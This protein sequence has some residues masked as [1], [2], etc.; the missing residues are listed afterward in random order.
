[1][2]AQ[3]SIIETGVDKLVKLVRERGRISVSEATK[4][5]NVGS[6]VIMEWAEF[7]E[8]E[9]IISIE[10]TL[11]QPFLV[12]RKLTKEQV[13]EKAK[14][15]ESKRDV[16]V[17]KAETSLTFLNEQIEYLKKVKEEFDGLNKKF[18]EEMNVIRKDIE[19][20]EKYE[21]LRNKIND[22]LAQQKKDSR[23]KMGRKVQ[24]LESEQKKLQSILKGIKEEEEE[25]ER[26]KKDTKSI[27]ESEKK[28]HRKIDELKS[29]INSIEK[30]IEHEDSSVKISANRLDRL[31]DVIINVKNEIIKEKTSV[32]SLIKES[33]K[34]DETIKQMQKEIVKKIQKN[35]SKMSNA[36]VLSKSIKSAFGRKKELAELFESINKNS[37]ELREELIILVKK[38]KAFEL[39]S[40]SKDIGKDIAGLESK[41]DEVHKKRT[42]IGD[43]YK[44]LTHLIKSK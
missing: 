10:Y 17:S 20:I 34:H 37:E 19:E 41:F 42:A 29:L 4:L 27:D 15:F 16:F 21:Q 8:E 13:K 23:E 22:E 6:S 24:Q 33:K 9:G 12:E 38:A 1:M 5:I 28:A 31:K 39:S 40:N 11:T 25:I 14:E 44:K 18:S 32:D 7:L 26:E 43:M 30:K 2:T 35:E 3:T 36:R